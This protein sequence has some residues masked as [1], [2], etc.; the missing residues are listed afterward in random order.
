M[1]FENTEMRQNEGEVTRTKISEIQV[2]S[3]MSKS[4]SN[5]IPERTCK[6]AA[7]LSL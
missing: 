6:G 7:C 1:E 2:L 3:R 4:F 5:N